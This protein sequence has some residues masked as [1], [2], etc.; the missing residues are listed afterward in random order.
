VNAL[1]PGAALDFAVAYEYNSPHDKPLQALG[2]RAGVVI[3][4]GEKPT[5]TPVA[6]N[7]AAYLREGIRLFAAKDYAGALKYF[8]AVA[9]TDPNSIDALK[10]AGNCYY[11]LGYKD[12]ARTAYTR[13][14]ALT[15]ADTQLQRAVSFLGG[16]PT[17]PAASTAP[18]LSAAG[19]K[20]L[21]E[22]ERLYA[23][24]DYLGAL[25]YFR[26]TADTDPQSADPLKG[27]GNCYYHLGYKDQARTAY[28]RALA[29]EPSNTQLQ[30]AVSALGGAVTETVP[31]ASKVLSTDGAK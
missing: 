20:Y 13:A 2:A 5:P 30:R 10:G 26:A 31:A 6:G 22:A 7:E 12:D 9:G 1:G 17:A 23:A 24:K 4:I 14:L 27:A 15:P 25:K 29:L 21:K 28:T 16:A 11:H 19:A 3:F 8:R 18:A